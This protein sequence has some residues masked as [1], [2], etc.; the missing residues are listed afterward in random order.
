MSSK[1]H[2]DV[3][4]AWKSTSSAILEISLDCKVRVLNNMCLNVAAA[5]SASSTIPCLA[6]MSHGVTEHAEPSDYSYTASSLC[7]RC[8]YTSS[9]IHLQFSVLFPYHDLWSNLLSFTLALCRPTSP[10]PK[11][12]LPQAPSHQPWAKTELKCGVKTVQY[13][14]VNQQIIVASNYH[15]ESSSKDPMTNCKP[16]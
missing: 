4:V 9:D 5:M 1:H 10:L 14:K 15:L 11:A 7:L 6:C 2:V 3:V 16:R 13:L 12:V 8:I